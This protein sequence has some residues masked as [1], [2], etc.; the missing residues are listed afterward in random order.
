MSCETNSS[1]QK[2]G[3]IGNPA[4]VWL[5]PAGISG[6]LYRLKPPRTKGSLSEKHMFIR[7]SHTLKRGGPAFGRVSNLALEPTASIA[8]G[9][10]HH[11]FTMRIH[12]H[13]GTHMDAPYHFNIEGKRIAELNL[14][15][16]IFDRPLIVDVPKSEASLITRSEL[17]SHADAIAKCDLLMLR[18]GY[19]RVRSSD[20]GKFSDRPPCLAPEAARYIV[21]ACPSVKG[22]A[23]DSVSVGSPVFKAE[24]VET[25][26]ILTGCRGYG[27]RYVLI[28]E[29]V[30]MDF[31][32]KTLKRVIVMPLFVEQID[33]SPCTII[34]EV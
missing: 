9:D 33:G 29:D 20:P 19:C 26:R 16:L 17:E 15:E 27:G 5:R 2:A 10:T 7:L 11:G 6:T 3:V 13:D 1:R 4:N 23:I 34:A 30:N 14:D 32:F 28:F 21:E 25:H 22:V 24:T 12:N 18:T 8:Q 31:D